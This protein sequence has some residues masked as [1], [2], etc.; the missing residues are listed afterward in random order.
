MQWAQSE[1]SSYFKALPYIDVAT[2]IMFCLS[3]IELQM[4]N[5]V[6]A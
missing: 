4:T 1:D 2:I 5:K 6:R 3:I